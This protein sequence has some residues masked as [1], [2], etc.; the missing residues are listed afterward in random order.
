MAKKQ[1]IAAAS[2]K[3]PYTPPPQ[4]VIPP[5]EPGQV[6]YVSVLPRDI[7]GNGVDTNP[8]VFATREAAQADCDKLNATR[9]KG[10]HFVVRT[11]TVY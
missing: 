11:M 5:V 1:A 3:K 9:M 2:V 10:S 8:K 4:V 6:V 7:F